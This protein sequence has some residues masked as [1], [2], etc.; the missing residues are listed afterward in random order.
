MADVFSEIESR[1]WCIEQDAAII[2]ATGPNVLHALDSYPLGCYHM[3]VNGA[4]DLPVHLHSR[5]ILDSLAPRCAWYRHN[6]G[7]TEI[8]TSVL[9][10][11]WAH[12]QFQAHADRPHIRAR[13]LPA[14][15]TVSGAAL[16]LLYWC[17]KWHGKP[18]TVYLAGCDMG[19]G[20]Y[21]N[22]YATQTPG[23]W[24]QCDNFNALIRE[25]EAGGLTVVTLTDTLL[26]VQH[27]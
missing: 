14:E 15:C 18:S 5:V 19:G 9:R 7:V 24:S 8:L 2:W 26:E 6:I 21:F 13:K 20:Q 17:Y 25:C 12:M 27:V 10:P 3:G 1:R 16:A 11:P 4:V 22:G 23:R